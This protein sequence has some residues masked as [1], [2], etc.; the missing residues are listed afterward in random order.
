VLSLILSHEINE[1]LNSHKYD[2]VAENSNPASEQNSS[3]SLA[4]I[5]QSKSLEEL[6]NEIPGEVPIT[7]GE[8][9]DRDKVL[10]ND[11]GGKKGRR[12]KKSKE[13]AERDKMS[14]Y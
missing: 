6:Q 5:T 4:A 2:S 14:V 10:E 12:E 11:F 9:A 13:D 7:I 3:A 8:V 1:I